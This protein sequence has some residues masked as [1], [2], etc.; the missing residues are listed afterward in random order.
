MKF[1]GKLTI[2]I[3]IL[4]VG[5]IFIVGGASYKIMSGLTME[6]S[7][8]S[9]ETSSNLIAEDLVSSFENYMQEKPVSLE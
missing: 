7:K 3:V 6:N 9:M 5:S 8:Q 4:V 1:R 2:S